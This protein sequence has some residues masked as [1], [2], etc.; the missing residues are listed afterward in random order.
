MNSEF[1]LSN[2]SET[3]F[4]SWKIKDNLIISPIL[5]EINIYDIDF[6]VSGST[7]SQ[8]MW[9]YSL[10]W[11]ARCIEG[12]LFLDKITNLLENFL[13]FLN[14]EKVELIYLPAK[15]H[16]YDHC[17]ALRIRY[18]CM[19]LA[20][21]KVSKRI[22]DV[23]QKVLERDVYLFNESGDIATNNH[24]LMWC[25]SILH[26]SL[27]ISGTKIE[28]AQHKA[29]FYLK[30]ILDGIVPENGYVAENTIGYHDF[31]YKF[32]KLLK[33][34]IEHYDIFS[35]LT[36]YIDN[37]F[38]K[39]EVA[40]FKVVMPNGN[41][42]PIGQSGFYPTKYRSISG[43]HLFLEQGFYVKKDDRNY[44]SYICGSKT[45]VHKQLDNTSITLNLDGEQ[46]FLDSGLGT[47]DDKDQRA[48][49]INGQRGH[50]GAFFK[51]FDF[52]KRNDFINSKFLSNTYSSIV[53]NG[54]LLSSI[55][56]FN[57]YNTKYIISREIEIK[58]FFEFKITDQ[59]FYEGLAD[60]PVSRFILPFYVDIDIQSDIII[61]TYKNF[62]LKITAESAFS[63]S[64][65]TASSNFEDKIYADC[66]ISPSYNNY[67]SCKML[68]FYP[69]SNVI[70]L[71]FHIEKNE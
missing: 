45:S 28:S 8:I 12:D 39:V 30:V 17:A 64:L 22:K 37:V 54:N 5:H 42:P 52:F 31:Y 68:E 36:D 55:N 3:S 10:G 2:F 29:I 61:I 65:K 46:I 66:W 56:S 23:C 41:I 51:K 33:N 14:T 1:Y 71:N 16:S 20:S 35:S 19:I 38:S 21:S 63:Y 59:F 32:L 49:A 34:F 6:N 13:F 15:N 4:I 18:N 26:A 58:N 9:F 24:G 53:L 62:L 67:E 50:S 25:V 69:S 47:Y 70:K 57:Y 48:V 43:S 27:F 44:F 60:S 40:L 11:L 7:Q